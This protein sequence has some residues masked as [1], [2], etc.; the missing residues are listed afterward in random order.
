MAC[1]SCIL[2][3]IYIWDLLFLFEL[4][5]RLYFHISLAIL[6]IIQNKTLSKLVNQEVATVLFSTKQTTT[7]FSGTVLAYK[8]KVLYANFDKVRC[9]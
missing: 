4:S 8:I 7:N 6:A 3:N 5:W 1:F 9:F 2:L